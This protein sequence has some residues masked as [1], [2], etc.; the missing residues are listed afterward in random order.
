[1]VSLQFGGGKKSSFSGDNDAGSG[2][3]YGKMNERTELGRFRQGFT[4]RELDE[5]VEMYRGVWEPHFR[6]EMEK[7]VPR[8]PWKVLKHVRSCYADLN[9]GEWPSLPMRHSLRVV[10]DEYVVEW[11][12]FKESFTG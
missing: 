4:G 10:K 8:H 9:G 7:E 5:M 1:M 11:R 6:A 12:E 3:L 2:D